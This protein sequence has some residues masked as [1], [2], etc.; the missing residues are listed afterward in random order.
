M[1]AAIG[2]RR[3]GRRVLAMSAALLALLAPVA[4]LGQYMTGETDIRLAAGALPPAPPPPTLSFYG[5]PG[6][7]D[8]PTAEALPDGQLAFST[9][10]FAGSTRNTLTFQI[11]PRLAGA[12]RYSI[13]ENENAGGR[14]LYDRSLD[15]AFQLVEE[16]R[17]LPGIAIG[18]RDIGGTSVL[19]SEYVAATKHL[20]P[21]VAITAGLGW[22]R[23]GTYDG[24]D[25]PLGALDDGFD[26]RETERDDPGGQLS[27]NYFQGDAAVFGGV[28]WR[29]TD[30]LSV[31][32]EYST[33]DYV[34]ETGRGLFERESPFN[35]G[36][37]YKVNDSITLGGYALYGTEIG[38]T[39][40][41]SFNPK[42]PPNG[43]AAGAPL[44]VL[45]RAP[46]A[47]PLS[48][49]PAVSTALR[50]AVSTALDA[51]GLGLDAL[52]ISGRRATLRMY[53]TT[54]ES[55]PMAVGRAARVLTAVMPSQ[56]DTF[57]IVPIVNGIPASAV[58]LR[59]GDLEDLEYAPDNAWTIYAR[60]RL[61]GGAAEGKLP[62]AAYPDDLYPKLDFG[63]SPYLQPALFD[64]DDPLRADVGLRFTA[65]YE[66]SPGLVLSGSLKKRL[67]GNR[68]EADRDDPSELPV[69]RSDIARY[70]QEGDPALEYLTGEYFFRPGQDYY[71]RVTAGLLERM[72]GGVS[73]EVLWKP[74]DSR[75]GLGV[76]LNYARKRDYDI[77]FDFQ[78]YE[79]ATGHASAY[80][81]F[82]GGYLGQIDAGRYLAGDWGAT[83]SLDRE[84]D[85]GARVGAFFTRTDVSA[86]EFGEGSFDKGIRVSIPLN[87][88]T[89]QPD[90]SSTGTSLRLV[91]RDGGQRLNV[92]NRLYGAVRDY[93]RPEYEDRSGA[94]WK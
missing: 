10:Y 82:G 33:D 74:V 69:V 46:G 81:D 91:Q 29:P 78:D 59:R 39:A 68:D 30:R 53:N 76:E 65:S 41:I 35:F 20:S 17:R 73:G 80:Y 66:P 61:T 45:R 18:L 34:Y 19:S 27:G 48:V 52:E 87:Y 38:I 12:F 11:F 79:T 22:G 26:V 9:A 54:Y 67:L 77:L 75:L 86:E 25:N 43:F 89:G 3:A 85:N 70:A 14:T 94:F 58:T 72:Y 36:A 50:D 6:L 92:R 23:L 16:D 5:T 55:A 32:A 44:P 83:F 71:G 21:K 57:V 28:E 56:V 24:F 62:P 93:H 37:K 4:T 13:I 63:I 2:T 7:I 90:R 51:Y 42:T 1:M 64:P 31:V 84:F 40:S 60:S 88:L 47:E 15:L 49:T 8:M